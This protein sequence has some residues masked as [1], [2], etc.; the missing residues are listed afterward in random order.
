MQK[1]RR[2]RY[3]NKLIKA[4]NNPILAYQKVDLI[5]KKEIVK[6]LFKSR[7]PVCTTAMR[8]AA[9]LSDGTVTTCCCDPRGI[10][11]YGN[12]YE[13]SFENIWNNG[14]REFRKVALFKRK[15]CYQCVGLHKM[16]PKL[17]SGRSERQ[18]WKT[19]KIALPESLVIEIS[20]RCNYSCEGCFSNELKN[21][22]EDLLDFDK[23]KERLQGIVKSVKRIRLYNY[24]EPMM[25]KDFCNAMHWINEISPKT[26][27]I[28]ATN[29]MLMGEK[30]ITAI[31]E[32]NTVQVSVSVHGGPGTE[33]M[34]RYSQKNADYDEA[35]RRAEE[36]IKKRNEKQKHKPIVRL[37]AILFNWNDTEEL[38]DKLRDDGKKIGVDRIVWALD[39]GTGQTS[40]ASKRY[41]LGSK[42]LEELRRRGEL[43]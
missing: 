41:R 37:K 27:I 25:N 3:L 30:E 23:A 19:E 24:G 20:G 31:L 39:R 18:K 16:S 34:L 29:A 9:V 21:H 35:L 12:I 14:F 36:L 43:D 4:I 28:I 40:R 38:M 17:L 13:D 10:N 7:E 26:E 11:R 22:R 2:N 1:T 15:K 42:N 8:E 33:N 6:R 5:V 32:S